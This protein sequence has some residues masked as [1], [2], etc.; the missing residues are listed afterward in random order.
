MITQSGYESQE[1]EKIKNCSMCNSDALVEDHESG[2]LI[3]SNCGLVLNERNYTLEQDWRAY[4]LV[5]EHQRSRSGY[6]LTN[7]IYDHGL[8]TT[9]ITC[10]N[11]KGKRLDPETQNTMSRLKRHDERTKINDTWQR[12]LKI[13][14]SGMSMICNKIHLPKHINE[15]A[16]HIYR[17][18][19]R[20][21]LIRGRSIE[22]FVSASIYAA[23][24]Q[25][26]V[27][28]SLQD[29][30]GASNLSDHVVKY[31]YRL[32]LTELEI[33]PPIDKPTKFLSSLTSKLKLGGVI[34]EHSMRILS[35]AHER[36]LI[37]GKNPRG[38]AAAILYLACQEEGIHI[39]QAEV[40]RAANTS[41][42]TMRKR[43]VEYES[44]TNRKHG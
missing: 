32:L 9:F 3:C 23:C 21:D 36:K 39:T 12:N 20:K 41:E 35:E 13:A 37:M 16:A 15:K 25:S 34:E 31:H 10:Y 29:I 33:K 5:E 30:A 7:T 19:L 6:G 43:F 28:R 44:F 22:G 18:A 4:S 14:L 1:L 26:G 40:A 8:S 27:P 42:V 11:S 2:E 38:V 17:K 24:R